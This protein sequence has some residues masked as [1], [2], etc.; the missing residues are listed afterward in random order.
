MSRNKKPISRLIQTPPQKSLPPKD[1]RSSI[2][3]V[4]TPVRPAM[5]PGI[6]AHVLPGDAPVTQRLMKTT[7]TEQSFNGP[8]PH[9][10]IFRKYGEVIPGAPERILRVFEE[11]SKHIRDIEVLAI[12]AK[13]RDN[14]RVHWMAW[15]LI[16]GGYVM[17]GLFASMNKDW[18]AGVVLT[19]TI[20]GTVTGFLQGQK[21]HPSEKI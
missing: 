4:N 5:L 19:T 21:E 3:Q 12:E 17:A 1:S 11:D 8:I 16:A 13:K 15:S 10:E 6:A 14:R 18:L 20:I 9:P 7:K 2:P